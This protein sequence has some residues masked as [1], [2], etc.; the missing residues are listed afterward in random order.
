[1]ITQIKG[2]SIN[3]SYNSEPQ[4]K[5]TTVFVKNND[6][7]T[8]MRKLKKVVTSEGIL[9]EFKERQAFVSPSERRKIAKN[10]AIKRRKKAQAKSNF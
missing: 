3:M 10:A 8:A 5:G 2:S 9:R 6:I 4:F 7:G 1:M